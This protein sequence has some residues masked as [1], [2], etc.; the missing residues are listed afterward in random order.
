MIRSFFLRLPF[1]GGIVE[2]IRLNGGRTIYVET[3][4]NVWRTSKSREFAR[5]CL[6]PITNRALKS[7]YMCM[8]VVFASI[9]LVSTL[10]CLL[11]SSKE[12][13][14]GSFL[15]TCIYIFFLFWHY[16]YYYFDFMSFRIRTAWMG[17]FVNAVIVNKRKHLRKVIKKILRIYGKLLKIQS[18][19]S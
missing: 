10:Q 15:F 19:I 8:C 9:S 14:I 16:C 17:H 13:F 6:V 2:L 7:I 4:H 1:N 12:N 11:I 5:T 18:K 3:S